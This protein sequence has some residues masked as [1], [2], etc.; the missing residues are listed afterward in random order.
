M[1]DENKLIEALKNNDGLDF[2]VPLNAL[3][4]PEVTKTTQA[5]IDKMKECFINLINAQPKEGEWI[6]T[7]E[8]LPNPFE[9]VLINIPGD[10]PLPTVREGYLIPEE[11][12]ISPHFN[13]A[14]T[15]GEVPFWKP[16]PKP[17]K[18]VK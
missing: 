5:I 3:T 12:W 17:P 9:S 7:E 10:S 13:E 1:I 8:R 15:M 11:I 18:E 2:E 16:M 14:Y 6:S 4:V